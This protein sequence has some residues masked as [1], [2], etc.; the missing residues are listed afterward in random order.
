MTIQQIDTNL[1][2]AGALLEQICGTI[3][4]ERKSVRES[5]TRGARPNPVRGY[6]FA[7]EAPGRIPITSSLLAGLIERKVS[8]DLEST[9]F[10]LM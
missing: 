10:P 7:G 6:V 4:A 5:E 1:H 9:H 2:L 8:P 3:G